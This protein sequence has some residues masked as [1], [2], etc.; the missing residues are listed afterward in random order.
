[1]QHQLPPLPNMPYAPPPGFASMM[2]SP[3]EALPPPPRYYDIPLG[4]YPPQLPT[5]PSR[6][7]NSRPYDRD[8]FLY[9]DRKLIPPPP[10]YARDYHHSSTS[11]TR[12]R[13][14]RDDRSHRNRN[15]RR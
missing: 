14:R 7:A 15:S 6:S 11:S 13:D 8:D 9:N 1:M 12:E 10:I 3:Y 5:V 2:Q 4:D